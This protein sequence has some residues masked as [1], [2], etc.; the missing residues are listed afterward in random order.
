MDNPV[1]VEVT[2][3]NIVESRHRGSIAIVDAD[4]KLAFSAGDV[5]QGIFARSAIKAL[6][7]IPMVESGAAEALAFDD[8]ELA[9]A[10]ASHNGEETHA[11]SARIM[12]FKAG[13]TEEDL[14]CGTQWPKHMD[15]CV[16]LIK[17]DESPCQLH[18]NCS[19]KHAGFLAMAKTLGVSTDNYIGYDHP[20]QA[21]I[22]NVLEQMG[23]SILGR[24]TC[25][26]D[27]CSIPTYAMEQQK[28]ALAFARFAT[29]VG[30]D[31]VRANATEVL[32]EA[33]VNEPYMVAGKNRFC[34]EIMDIFKGRVFVKVGAEGVFCAALPE[35]GFGVT[36]KCD[37]GAE[38]GAEVMMASVIRSLLPLSED[39]EKGLHAWEHQQLMNRRDILVGEVR[40]VEDIKRLLKA[41]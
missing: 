16:K 38:R 19:G 7:A 31:P 25:G 15:D 40:P 22:R 14:M 6:Q 10:C 18:N 17:T 23:G 24:D 37:D 34:T 13:L 36:L 29:G 26:T 12:L 33:C 30:L 1:L 28:T 32:Y 4:G 9:L 8:A 3:G 41:L 5:E 21:E 35:L 27:G 11:N 20:V 39:E 2:R